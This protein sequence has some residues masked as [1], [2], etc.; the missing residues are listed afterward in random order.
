MALW[1]N[2][3][4]RIDEDEC[5]SFAG[6]FD[7]LLHGDWR[8]KGIGNVG[9]GEQLGAAGELAEESFVIKGSVTRRRG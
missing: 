1:A 8:S 5:V 7:E 3:L 6:R 4:G 9:E 2:R